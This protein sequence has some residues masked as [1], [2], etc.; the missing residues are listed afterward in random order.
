MANE[1]KYPQSAIEAFPQGVRLDLRVRLAIDFL[2][3]PLAAEYL[4]GLESAAVEDLRAAADG[5]EP[6][7]KL[8]D[9]VAKF[10]L[11]LAEAVMVD[12]EQRGWTA[13]MPDTDELDA[14]TKRQARR[15]ARFQIEGQVA[16]Q[17]AMQ[18]MAAGAIAT[19][20]GPRMPS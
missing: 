20:G 4:K 11:D 8:A 19:P 12:A 18:E 17:R 2:K 14:S 1:M 5:Q 15:N 16:G 9:R 7:V 13:P 6:P 3:T 10:T